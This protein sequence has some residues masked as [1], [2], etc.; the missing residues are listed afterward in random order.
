MEPG[1]P[2][3]LLGAVQLLLVAA[4]VGLGAAA[5]VRRSAAGFVVLAGALVLVGVEVR[6]GLQLGV[7][8]SDGLALLRAAGYLVVA[9]GLATGGLGRRTLPTGALG[10]VLP[11][12]STGG[13]A[14]F[15]AV[16]AAAAAAG[17]AWTQRGR[18]SLLLAVG[19]GL[20]AA[21]SAVSTGA[22]DDPKLAVLV[23]ILRGVGALLLL[24]A[25]VVLAQASLLTKVVSAIL[26]GVLTMA[27]AAVGVV[28]NVVVSSYDTQTRQIVEEAAG[29]RE[30][31][32]EALGQE[33][34]GQAVTLDVLRSGNDN[35]GGIVK[36]LQKD[37]RDF[38]LVIDQRGQI[39][40]SGGNTPLTASERLGL[41]NVP[42]IQ[43]V[44]KGSGTTRQDSVYGV[45]R[46]GGATP[47]LVMMGVG[48]KVDTPR[49]AGATSAPRAVVVYG[50]RLDAIFAQSDVDT[51]GFGLT[52]LAGD[53]LTV[54]ATNK[55]TN[56]ARQVQRLILRNSAQKG[57]DDA[58]LTIGS[59]GTNPTVRVVA[60]K[61][62]YEEG[63]Q[64]LLAV[65]RDPGPALDTER[66][67]LK[68]LLVTALLALLLVAVAAV[69]LGR[70]TVEPV[71]RLTDAAERVAAG[72]LT[73][74]TGV[75]T[76]DEVGT[77]SRTFDGMTTSLLGLTGDLRAS[78]ARLETVLASMT[79][80]LL[81]TDVD[82]IVTATNRA[83]LEML[84]L[85]ELDVLG[86]PLSV[87]ADVRAPDGEP[88]ADIDLRLRDEPGLVH[89]AD[90]STVP[91]QVSITPLLGDD[92]A[93]VV[94]VL[95]DT[96][97]ER[98]V[99]RMKTDFLSNVSHELRTP[100]TPIRGYADILISKGNL[101]PEQVGT[102]ATVIRDEALKMNRVV[103]L[104][105]DVA[106]IEAGRVSV[107]PR[108]VAVREL[109]DV[110]LA[111]WNKRA[112]ARAGDLK[113]RAA[114]GLPKVYVD[115]TWIGK[116]LDEFIDNAVKY[117]APGTSITLLAAWSPDRTRVRLSVKDAGPGIAEDDQATLFTS[118]EQVD[119]SATRRVGGLGL[120]LSFVRRL[121][122][123]AGYPLAVSSRLGKGAEFSLD[124]PVA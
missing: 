27:V 30:V 62:T 122:Q 9:A 116:A 50:R 76:R 42:L 63:T 2:F 82:G 40:S 43:A 15:A 66:Q 78:A 49:V 118:F 8:S 87:V 23:L 55:S 4:F 45:V 37:R 124:V 36:L 90:G 13:P 21:G 111:A 5:V 51:G 19:F 77:L 80:G 44:L 88:L 98:E 3:A 70:R 112:P 32:L 64:G 61:N 89:R 102:F 85:D 120:G 110:R 72:D 18:T 35:V 53:P 71:R 6:T 56:T 107:N 24:L 114:T 16:S 97:Q 109:L 28:G 47:S 20:L 68:V 29:G 46:L 100:L 115:P 33:V 57:V 91:V 7:V 48:V 123:D 119:G 103:D 81:A 59:Q 34:A 25:L 75:T 52:L 101:R 41:A 99:E 14:A 121:A 58:G 67:A 104:L 74:T 54:V 84:G 94:L 117:S 69:V 73:V 39:L 38:A 17:A 79:D 65:S 113:R 83:A 96:T 60:L 22:K 92:D 26:A 108:P 106:A 93:G 105:V 1:V 31:A 12:A 10:I 95:R 11:L 86:E